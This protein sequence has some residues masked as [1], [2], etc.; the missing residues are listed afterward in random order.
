M[1]KIIILILCLAAVITA[2]ILSG[3]L[4]EPSQPEQT[5]VSDEQT[6]SGQDE[7][8]QEVGDVRLPYFKGKHFNPFLTDS[9]T[10]LAISTLLYDSL[11]V[12]NEDWSS[13]ALIA[14][15]FHNAGKNLTVKLVDSIAFSNGQSLT[16][17]DVVYSFKLAQKSSA[18]K[19]RLSNFTKATAGADTVTFTLNQPDVYAQ[20][21]LTFPIVQNGT[22]GAALPIGSGRYVL[23][24]N[25][26]QY[27][28]SANLHNTRNETLATKT[29]SLVPITAEDDEI[30]RVQ[31]GALSYYYNDMSSGTY[32][33]LTATT[34]PLETNNL[35]YLGCNGAKEVFKNK[36]VINAL[37]LAIDK[38][39]LADTVFD[40]FCSLTETPFNP[41][42]FAL[43]NIQLPSYE[44][45]LIKAGNILD[46]EGYNY[47]PNDRSY[48]YDANGYF[49]IKILVNKE[50]LT[51]I[52]C[53]K[54]I[55]KAL[56]NLGINVSL[57][58]L[59][60]SKYVEA[61]RNGEYDLYIGEVRIS[62]NMDLGCFFSKNG[63][64]SYGITSDTIR[65][66]YSDFK[67][68]N[69]DINTF[70]G[71][72]E[73]EAPFIPVCYRTSI[74]YYSNEVQ[75]EGSMN[76]YDPF[77]NIN[78]WKTEKVTVG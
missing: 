18:Y 21:C 14:K 22:G 33:K 32:T 26:G 37:H 71:V 2:V 11:F 3:K 9:P 24:S 57:E 48:R 30:Y 39:T 72:F 27:V 54:F 69:I 67:A 25:N 47:S 78:T 23:R 20:Q 49:S 77:K 46:E 59:E 38:N 34:K 44:Y 74:A 60:Y 4:T 53:A 63:S 36:N 61:L 75:L 68:G 52:N 43:R 76:E 51:K 8:V 7:A 1:K 16:A 50:S 58:A 5:T 42:W 31:T 40:N 45:N 13:S 29:I 17:Y 15:E 6:S 10:N 65:T 73:S 62:P 19:G 56:L 64:A 70:I 41:S 35:I 28:L 55:G 12:M 66:A